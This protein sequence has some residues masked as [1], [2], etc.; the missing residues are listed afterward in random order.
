[1]LLFKDALLW[2][3]NHF[4]ENSLSWPSTQDSR[5]LRP[6]P[7]IPTSA[8]PRLP[9]S[10]K[11]LQGFSH[12][13]VNDCRGEASTTVMARSGADTPR[14]A[15][16][17]LGTAFVQQLTKRLAPS[18]TPIIPAVHNER[19][20]RSGRFCVVDALYDKLNGDGPGRRRRGV[21]LFSLHGLSNLHE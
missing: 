3:R 15:V 11:R 12:G 10:R 2:S 17:R 14:C 7:T 9:A 21:I 1:M 4:S 20:V 19:R 16:N 6:P 13:A 5:T 8:I 18:W